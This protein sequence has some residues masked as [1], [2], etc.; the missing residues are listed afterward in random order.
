MKTFIAHPDGRGPFPA[1]V[2][3][4]NVGGLGDVLRGMAR[5]VAEAGYY[6][7]VGSLY[8]RLGTIVIDPDSRNEKVMAVRRIAA[9]SL[10]NA[11]VMSDTKAL[12][13]FMDSDS[14]V[15]RG[16]MGTIGF[17]QGG[18]F[19]VLAAATF[20]ERFKA[21]A[22]LFGTKLVTDG[23]DSPHLIMNRIQG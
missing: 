12:L 9:D 17:C 11:E 10:D 18:R 3:F 4:Q 23:P 2:M 8:Y 15:R 1:V 20:P 21:V 16:P 19:T 13:E 5:R 6:C 7:A 14:A 22:S